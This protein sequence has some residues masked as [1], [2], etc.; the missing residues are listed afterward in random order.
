MI[1]ITT[2][3]IKVG[4]SP[5]SLETDCF[6]FIIELLCY[7]FCNN[8]D[9]IDSLP[10]TLFFRNTL[11]HM[12]KLALQLPELFPL[13][14]PLP[15][16]VQNGKNNNN[17]KIILYY[18]GLSALC[19][20]ILLVVD[21]TVTL[22]RHQIAS[23]LANAFFCTFI[24]VQVHRDKQGNIQEFPKFN[25]FDNFWRERGSAYPP[26][27]LVFVTTITG[28][29]DNNCQAYP[30]CY[31]INIMFFQEGAKLQCI[32]HY[33]ERIIEEGK[34]NCIAKQLFKVMLSYRL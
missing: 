11:P 27:V 18:V 8:S 17:I 9:C 20:D 22:T 29:K 4:A 15:L 31:I 7:W 21:S 12:I 33:F 13:N 19:N 28:I 24:E 14:Q 34:K 6:S 16:L 3:T 32:I 5:K 23:L 1:I 2:T 30:G 25:F 10:S 26:Q